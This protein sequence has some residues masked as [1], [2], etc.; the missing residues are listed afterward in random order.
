LVLFSR[1]TLSLRSKWRKPSFLLCSC[2]ASEVTRRVKAE[3]VFLRDSLVFLGRSGHQCLCIKIRIRSLSPYIT[4]IR[5]DRRNQ[6]ID[7]VCVIVAFSESKRTNTKANRSKT[8][9]SYNLLHQV[10]FRAMIDRRPLSSSSCVC[11]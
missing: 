4:L 7:C 5:L 6:A 1:K 3:L 11:N 8:N 10:Q 9:E 2:S